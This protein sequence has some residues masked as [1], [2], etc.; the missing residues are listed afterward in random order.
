MSGH[1][2]WATIK[3][4]KAASDAKKGKVISKMIKQIFIVVRDGG[5]DPNSNP[6]LRLLLQ[7]AR[8]A[9]VNKDNM[10]RAIARASG[11]GG[12][13]IQMEELVYEA[14]APGGAALLISAVTDNRNRTTPEVRHIIEGH[15]GKMAAGG[16]VAWM[17]KRKGSITVKSDAAPE[18]KLMELVLEAGAEDF[19]SDGQYYV[20]TT[21]P[22]DFSKVC[23]AL[24]KAGIKAENQELTQEAEN[25]IQLDASAAR[26]AVSTMQALEDQEDVNNVYTNFEMTADLAAELAKS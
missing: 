16:S 12:D 4:K 10:D 1:S 15:G 3:H 2:H 26:K 11:G 13:G 14:Y 23:D 22:E 25:K 19:D 18:D 24:E 5:P 20:I 6:A 9:G 7:K 21:A 8:Q 17:F